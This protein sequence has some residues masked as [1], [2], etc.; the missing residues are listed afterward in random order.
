MIGNREIDY[1]IT[2]HPRF[3]FVTK[4]YYDKKSS[5]KSHEHS[6]QNLQNNTRTSLISDKTKSK[7]GRSIDYI[8]HTS[9]EQNQ[10]TKQSNRNINFKLVFITLTLS[11]KQIHT[12]NELKAFFLNHLITIIKRK[13]NID[14]YIWRAEKQGNGNLHFHILCNKF[15]PHTELRELWNN[16]Q[17]KLGYIDRYREHMKN[18]YNNGF[19]KSNNINDKRS[20]QQQYKAYT[21]GT[22]T[23]WSQPNSTDIHSLRMVGNLKAYFTT[24]FYKITQNEGLEGRIWGC[25]ENLSNLKGARDHFENQY[26]NEVKKCLT[27]INY[28]AKELDFYSIYFVTYQMLKQNNCTGLIKLFDT[29]INEKFP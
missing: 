5:K 6:L 26:Y 10:R 22:M 13:Y 17:N 25:S 11:S 15:I 18:L 8:I 1:N 23:D 4:D 2:V 7:I 27:N 28:Q 21:A 24:Y 14:K 3:I 29:Y 20:I 12:D 16:V 9:K 19:I